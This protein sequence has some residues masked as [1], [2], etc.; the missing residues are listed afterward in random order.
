[1]FKIFR[2][3]G[4]GLKRDKINWFI[5]YI[6]DIFILSRVLLNKYKVYIFYPI[7]IAIKWI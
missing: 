5:A 6:D 4:I 7:S 1:M 3:D 2:Y